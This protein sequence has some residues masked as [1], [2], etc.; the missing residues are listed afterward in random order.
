MKRVMKDSIASAIVAI[1]RTR[2]R[3]PLYPARYSYNKH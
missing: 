2:L 3:L 1:E